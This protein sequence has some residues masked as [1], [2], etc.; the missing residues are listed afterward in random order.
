MP[1]PASEIEAASFLRLL[2][3]GSPKSGKSCTVIKS[4]PGFS[5]VINSDDVYSLRPVL[6]FTDQFEYDVALGTELRSIEKCIHFARE[7]VKAGKY[8]TIIWDTITK[9]VWRAEDVF[10]KATENGQ[11]EPDGRR[12]HP[13][14][15]KHV[16]NI[17]DR[18]FEIP[19]H[20]IVNS[21]WADVAGALIDN[22]LDKEGDGIAPMLVG[23]LRVVVPAAFQ[24]VVFL[25][26]KGEKRDFVT[27]SS[28]VWGPGCRNLPGVKTMPADISL[29]WGEMTKHN[30]ATDKKDGSVK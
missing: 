14:L 30:A 5:Y 8:Q 28:G 4:A 13:K 20:V 6:Q 17:L 25:E 2:V 15:R 27:S 19:A 7:G 16:L 23:Q 1:R 22:Q 10:A 18:L 29:L 12:Y 24:D 9:Y 3:L 11:G 26:K 21:H